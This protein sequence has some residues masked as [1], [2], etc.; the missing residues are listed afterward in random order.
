MPRKLQALRREKHFNNNNNSDK[1]PSFAPSTLIKRIEHMP[2]LHKPSLLSTSQKTKSK[3]RRRGTDGW[4][5]ASTF[6]A[7]CTLSTPPPLQRQLV[8]SLRFLLDTDKGPEYTT[9]S[10]IR[11][12]EFSRHHLVCTTTT[13]IISLPDLPNLYTLAAILEL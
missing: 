6:S 13:S 3:D 10:S 1:S 5:K 2:P 11:F 9:T 8:L 7:L 4:R 12:L